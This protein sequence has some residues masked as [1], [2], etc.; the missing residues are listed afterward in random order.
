MAK[1]VGSLVQRVVAKVGRSG[2]L[3]RCAVNAVGSSAQSE[4]VPWFRKK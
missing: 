4:L 1:A 2:G 3:G